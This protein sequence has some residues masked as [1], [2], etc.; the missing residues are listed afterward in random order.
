[1]KVSLQNGGPFEFTAETKAKA[2]EILAKYPKDRAQSGVIPLLDLAQRQQGWVSIEVIEYVASYLNM[3]A[4]KAM[5]VATFYTMFN[6][7]PI[8]KYHVQVCTNICCMLKD[9][10]QV[11]KACKDVLGIGSGETTEDGKFTVQ[12]VECAGACVNAPVAQIGDDYFEDL[13]YDSTKR[14]LE[15]L[16]EDKWPKAGPQ[17]DRLNSAPAGGPTTLKDFV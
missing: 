10:D 11:M 2:D 6:L 13:D 17:T 15:S 12:E 8:G 4:V 1:M 16:K 3:P 14:I 7:N 9:S 5:E